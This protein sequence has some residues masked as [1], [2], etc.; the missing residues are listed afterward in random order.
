MKRR[1]GG[2]IGKGLL[3]Q[4]PLGYPAKRPEEPR[5]MLLE[6]RAQ[7]VS[8]GLAKWETGL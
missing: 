4:P 7:R 8:F 1:D 3:S 2:E 6:F 5:H